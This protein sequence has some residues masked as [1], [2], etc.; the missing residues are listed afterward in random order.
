VPP[1]DVHFAWLGLRLSAEHKAELDRRLLDLVLEF[2][3][4]G[5]DADGDAYSLVTLLHPDLNPRRT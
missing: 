2:K 4:R 5:P 3:D 1:E